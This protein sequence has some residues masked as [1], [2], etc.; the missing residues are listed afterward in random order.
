MAEYR[1][2]RMGF[3]TDPYIEELDAKAKLLYIY[4]FTGPYTNNLGIVEATRRKIAYE[5]AMTVQEVDKLRFIP[6]RVG[7]T[8]G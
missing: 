3:W 7:N 4:L 6:T 5:T 2:I 1:T 8:A